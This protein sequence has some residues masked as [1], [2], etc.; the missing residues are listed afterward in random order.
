M[1]CS[2]DNSGIQ[3]CKESWTN[4]LAMFSIVMFGFKTTNNGCYFNVSCPEILDKKETGTVSELMFCVARAVFSL[5][6]WSHSDGPQSAHAA[7][8]QSYHISISR[9]GDLN[10][11]HKTCQHENIQNLFL[12][13]NLIDLFPVLRAMNTNSCQLIQRIQ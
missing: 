8:I 12:S 9:A 5:H 4:I 1:I 11:N 6:S 13:K 2:T 7:W 3:D 10:E